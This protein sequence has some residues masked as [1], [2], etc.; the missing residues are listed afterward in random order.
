MTFGESIRQHRIEAGFTV[1]YL[2][3]VTGI[4]DHTIHDLEEDRRRTSFYVVWKIAETLG[5]GIDE[6]IGREV[7]KGA[8]ND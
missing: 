7:K 3:H 2:A 1:K 5:I 6:L 8:E 4:S